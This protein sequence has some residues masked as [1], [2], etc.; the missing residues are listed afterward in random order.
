MPR[1]PVRA[2]GAATVVAMG[3]DF[4]GTG[5]KTTIGMAATAY[6]ENEFHFHLAAFWGT[7]LTH[8]ATTD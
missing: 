4:T 8:A 1:N 5:T 7:C 3:H 2:A 6:N